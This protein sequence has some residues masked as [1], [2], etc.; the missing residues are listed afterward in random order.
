M[1]IIST[2]LAACSSDEPTATLASE[3]T[4]PTDAPLT[5]TSVPPTALPPPPTN[6]PPPTAATFAPAATTTPV[7]P[8]HTAVLPAIAN[9]SFTDLTGEYL[10]QT[11]PGA[12]PEVFAPGVI[13]VDDHFE[14]S[15][16]VFSPD[17]TE[18]YWAA[19]PNGSNM[20]HIYFMKSIDG[21][22]TVPQITLFTEQYEGNRPTFSPDGQKLY[23]ESI[24]HPLGGPILFVERQGE[25]WSDPS[26]VS[27]V[28]NSSG[29]E[30]PFNL[31]QNG[32]MYFARGFREIEQILVSNFVDG[33]FVE[34]VQLLQ[35]IDSDLTELHI[36]VA[37]DESYMIIES[38][39]HTSYF[40]LSISYKMM[41]GTWSER[42]ILSYDW[43]RFP[44]VSPD[45][46]YLF[47]MGYEGIY[48]VSTS[49]V[50]ELK[51]DELK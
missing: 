3:T 47:F 29:M 26:P 2:L 40:D 37:P 35:N 20:F 11:P 33:H 49:F 5:A 36:Y 19:K 31:T 9:Y 30:R 6:T 8:T 28:I 45:G 7:L 10:G 17:K 39:D 24:R 43:A 38:T 41:D 14:H 44:V 12:T 51:P 13:S 18:V 21:R 48:W 25:G 27:P 32:S 46:K 34:P 23:Y 16:A 50:E 15:G 1:I 22:W 4:P 42:V